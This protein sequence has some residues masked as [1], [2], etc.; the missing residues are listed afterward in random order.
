MVSIEQV[1][2]GWEWGRSEH[3]RRRGD[4]W[5]WGGNG[6]GAEGS[7]TVVLRLPRRERQRHRPALVSCGQGLC[8]LG[9]LEEYERLS[10]NS[11]AA[12]RRALRASTTANLSLDLKTLFTTRPLQPH[13]LGMLGLA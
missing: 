3:L 10:P 12:I 5:G 8:L 4:C 1:L 6:S 9:D 11:S 13:S 2:E 7:F